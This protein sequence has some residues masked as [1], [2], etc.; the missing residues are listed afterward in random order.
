[1]RDQGRPR[2]QPGDTAASECHTPRDLGRRPDAIHTSVIA[3]ID[4]D[5]DIPRS[6]NTWAR[7]DDGPWLVERVT[8]EPS[9]APG[10]LRHRLM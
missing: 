3:P 8:E 7:S 2:Q 1:M 5:R 4:G 9:G 6:Q 10:A